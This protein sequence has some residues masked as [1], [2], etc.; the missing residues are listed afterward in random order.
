MIAIINKSKNYGKG[1]QTYDLMINKKK[2]T[3]F[4]H[5]FEDGLAECLRKASEA[6]QREDVQNFF[7]KLCKDNKGLPKEFA[8][9]I[10][11]EFW[12]LI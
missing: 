1:V 7:E 10:D 3:S 6:A 11:K 9:V 5:V 4:T 2:I 12:N 8:K